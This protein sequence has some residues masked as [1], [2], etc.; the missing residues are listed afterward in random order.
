MKRKNV[1]LNILTLLCYS[2]ATA[3]WLRKAFSGGTGVDALLGFEWGW[4]GLSSGLAAQRGSS[5]K[6]GRDNKRIKS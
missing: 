4:R 1:V 6:N 3:I 2:T 5:A